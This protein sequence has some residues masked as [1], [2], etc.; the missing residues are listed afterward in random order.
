MS[1]LQKRETQ[2]TK[3]TWWVGNAQT[4]EIR[5]IQIESIIVYHFTHPGMSKLKSWLMLKL[6]GLLVEVWVGILM[7]EN[8]QQHLARDVCYA[9]CLSGPTPACIPREF[10]L[11]VCKGIC[12]RMFTSDCH[13]SRRWR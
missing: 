7:L 12:T 2:M 13:G 11:Q 9:P 10:I 3:E 1:N 5:E 4:S 6:H 8:N